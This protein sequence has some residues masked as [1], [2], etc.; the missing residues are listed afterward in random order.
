MADQKIRS[1]E[2]VRKQKRHRRRWLLAVIV[3]IFLVFGG[4]VWLSHQEGVQIQ[5]FE[6]TASGG[7]PEREF[8]RLIDQQLDRSLWQMISRRNILLLPRHDIKQQITDL[9]YRV[10]SVDIDITG[11]RQFDVKINT[12]KPDA[13]VCPPPTATTSSCRVVDKQGLVFADAE[14]RATTSL[15]YITEPIPDPGSQLL[16]EQT[17]RLLNSFMNNLPDVGFVPTSVRL[18]DHS[19]AV[20]TVREQTATTT[21]PDTTVDIKVSLADN[22]NQAFL[23]LKTVIQKR[24]FKAGTSSDPT[25][26]SQSAKTV[27]PTELEYIDVRFGNKVFYR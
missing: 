5:E 9:T 7:L 18:A 4:I 14:E 11:L 3:F 10:R 12:R 1:Q 17:Y 20:I 16:P 21:N 6:V 23:D 25:A 13:P 24:A 26:E 15:Q 19:D 27:A 22:L 2:H 8:K